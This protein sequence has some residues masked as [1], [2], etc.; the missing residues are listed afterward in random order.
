MNG[1]DNFDPK[2]LQAIKDSITHWQK[3]IVEP[4]K[5][6]EEVDADAYN[7]TTCS[8]CQLYGFDE[9]LRHI[10]NCDLCPLKKYGYGCG[11]FSSPWRN[12]HIHR[13]TAAALNMV[14]ALQE[15]AIKYMEGAP[16]EILEQGIWQGSCGEYV[17]VGKI[18]GEW[19]Y[20]YLDQTLFSSVSE[21]QLKNYIKSEHWQY[22]PNAK[23]RV[24]EKGN[25]Q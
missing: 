25:Q 23:I 9:A 14:M 11:G 13:D 18:N 1:K 7:A 16:A 20:Y 24:I 2:V 19:C 4:L 10:A 6:G 22:C 17:L 15:V 5:R 21:E 8:L 3:D 12:F